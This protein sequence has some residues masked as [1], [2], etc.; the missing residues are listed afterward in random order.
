MI[1]Y[2]SKP[3]ARKERF[4]G[5]RLG[6][7]FVLSQALYHFATLSKFRETGHALFKRHPRGPKFL[8]AAFGY[9]LEL[10][11]GM[12]WV[13]SKQRE[14]LVRPVADAGGQSPVFFPKVRIGTVH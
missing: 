4:G 9:L 10:Q 1:L 14:L 12:S 13:C 7:P 3:V 6:T 5:H 8:F 11:R 2:E